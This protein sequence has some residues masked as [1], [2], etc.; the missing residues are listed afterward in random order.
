MNDI[1]E[2]NSH[3]FD[4]I[5]KLRSKDPKQPLHD[6]FHKYNGKYWDKLDGKLFLNEYYTHL[7]K[8]GIHIIS[9]QENIL[10]RSIATITIDEMDVESD[11][12]FCTLSGIVDIK[13]IYRLKEEN[14]NCNLESCIDAW[15]KPH[16][17]FK[18]N[19][20]TMCAPV[21]YKPMS[22]RDLQYFESVLK[23]DIL[24]YD[25]SSEWFLDYL[26]SLLVGENKYQ[27]FLVFLGKR[28]TGKTTIVNLI[29]EI[30]GDYAGQLPEGILSD[31]QNNFRTELYKIR[32]KRVLFYD[33]PSSK[34]IKASLVKRI[35]GNSFIEFNDERFHIK[36]KIIIDSN[37]ILRTDE[38]DDEAFKERKV[39]I[40]F[41]NYLPEE[42][43]ILDI[44]GKLLSCKDDIFSLMV[45]HVYKYNHSI[46][47]KPNVSR[48]VMEKSDWLLPMKS[49]KIFYT[50]CCQPTNADMRIKTSELYNFFLK[51]FKQVFYDK[52]LIDGKFLFNESELENSLKVSITEFN[53]EIIH[54][55]GDISRTG[56]ELIL[57]GLTLKSEL[58]YWGDRLEPIR[59][60]DLNNTMEN[61]L[62]E[63]NHAK[64]MA[65][66][67]HAPLNYTKN[68]NTEISGGSFI[69]KCMLAKGFSRLINS[70]ENN[71]KKA[72]L[73]GCFKE[74]IAQ[75]DNSD[76][77]SRS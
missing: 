13:A 50:T 61:A 74:Q 58:P 44:L 21:I 35:T 76:G 59:N 11:F 17:Q 26:G 51:H 49:I 18:K 7:E 25:E 65:E 55:H 1:I 38:I 63:L 9:K 30:M 36:S 67:F 46:V 62:G 6:G 42:N 48:E 39:E 34:A 5:V 15:L 53:R 52:L 43:R 31:K 70:T 41:G 8:A 28:R 37:Y 22:K 12:L 77:Q 23:Q 47:S 66:T 73:L 40:P 54:I 45:D 71:F 29:S 20:I 24:K 60:N 10:K 14:Q 57:N 19:Y 75:S 56:N 72:L 64:G 2:L 3:F 4:D 68:L 32:K 69:R 16:E 33:E 27:Q